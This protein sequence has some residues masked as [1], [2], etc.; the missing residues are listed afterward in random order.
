MITY[1]LYLLP[2]SLEKSAP[3]PAQGNAAVSQNAPAPEPLLFEGLGK[4]RRK[5][6]T[7]SAQAQRYFDQGLN[8]L[9][10][11]NHDEAIRSFTQAAKLD[12]NCAMAWWGI[13]IA[14]GPHINNPMGDEAHAEAAWQAL[15]EA[16]E[17]KAQASP[18]EQA[19]IEAAQ[20]R[21]A[22]PQPADRKPLDTAY[23]QA[24]REVWKKFPQDADVGALFAEAMMDLRPWDLWTQDGQP[25]PG[26]PEIVETLERVLTLDR[27][28]PLG[29]HLY[30]HAVEASP[31]PQ[32]ALDA[33]DRLRNLQPALGHMVHMPSHIDV[34]CGRWKEAVLAN[35]RAIAADKQYRQKRPWQGF[36]RLYMLHNHHMLAYAA[37]MRGQSAE[38][39]RA[40]DTMIAGVPEEW[41]RQNAA[42]ADG[43]IAMPVEMRV[44][45]GRWDEVLSAPEPREYF[46]LARAMWRAS[47]G[48]AYAAKN[49]VEE[50]RAEQAAFL[51]AAAL[52]PKEATFGNNIG[53]DILAVATHM[54]AGEIL[55]RAGQ[56]EEG[57]NELREAV[58]REDML[59]YD[60]PPSWIIPVRHALGAALLQAECYPEA[61][62]VYRDDLKKLPN[63][64]WS[65]YG[66]SRCLEA[67]GQHE[68]AAKAAARF[69]EVWADADVKLTSS[70]F[71]QPGK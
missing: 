10:A 42:I 60:E 4:H 17:K 52:V 37:I 13:A 65:L 43:F 29:L 64:G 18:V 51:K 30:I 8:F 14:N 40:V 63:N 20:A 48:I 39:I 55:F 16:V 58:R 26:T 49:Q 27:S 19:L 7:A 3:I 47:R 68:E 50:A 33:A 6:T 57:L 23:A 61:A 46:P 15:T 31:E 32:K 21:Y 12:P 67:Q 36:Y 11:F 9:F 62:Q 45:F 71:C 1:V 69:Q 22:H 24:M 25:Q 54:L 44:R 2:L 35:E 28:H 56:V 38:A 59:R 70:C 53:S 5:V 41:A 34:R 66:L